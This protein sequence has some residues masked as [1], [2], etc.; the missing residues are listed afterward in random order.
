MRIRVDKERLGDLAFDYLWIA[1]LWVT[2]SMVMGDL[3]EPSDL[4]R[5]LIVGSVLIG[6][7]VL[8]NLAK[9]FIA[10]TV[11]C[12]TPHRRRSNRE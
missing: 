8:W 12:L 2:M 5:F 3:D 1:M 6:A 9:A 10:L 4:I 11:R 7:I